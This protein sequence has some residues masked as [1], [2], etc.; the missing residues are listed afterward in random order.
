MNG[1]LLD[2]NLLLTLLDPLHVHH[3]IAR[4][5]FRNTG[6]AAWATCPLTENGFLRVASH[7]SYPNR[8]GDV[9][10][11][12]G[13][14]R[15]FC[16]TDGHHFWSDDVS[17]R[18]VPRPNAVVTSGQVTDV[19]LLALAAHHAGKLATLDRRLPATAI[20]RGPEHL[21]LLPTGP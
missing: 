14:L 1:Y 20:E 13:I 12:L 4:A 3:E 15:R 11:V 21:E 8:P 16:S 19:Y 17:F 5:W 7:H 18:D 6:R 2:V 10:A 9:P